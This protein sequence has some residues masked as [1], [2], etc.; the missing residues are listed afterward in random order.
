MVSSPG[1]GVEFRG[2]VTFWEIFIVNKNKIL[3][4]DPDI[5]TYCNPVYGD[6]LNWVAMK[7]LELSYHSSYI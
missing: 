5:P 4:L 7:E 2:L 6:P 1:L 3:L